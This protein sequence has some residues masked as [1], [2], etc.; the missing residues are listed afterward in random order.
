MERRP[1]VLTGIR[2]LDAA[3]GTASPPTDLRIDGGR[4][5]AIGAAV[6]RR[7]ADVVDGTG[8]YLSPGFVDMHAHPLGDA[9]PA[10]KLALMLSYGITAF[11]QM[12]GSDE[13]LAARA[14]GTLRLPEASPALLQLCGPLLIGADAATP[15]LAEAEVRRQVALGVDFVKVIAVTPEALAAAQRVARELDV[16]ILGHL[17][18]GVDVR[19]VSRAGYRSI[20]HLGPGLA[21]PAAVSREEERIREATASMR[22]SDAVSAGA[23]AAPDME[24]IVLNP[25]LETTAATLTNL[26]LAVRSFDEH[27]ARELARRFV[28]DG[29]WH[30]V[31]L[32]RD[33]TMQRADADE[34]AT[35]PDLHHRRDASRLGWRR[36]H[37]R[38]PIQRGAARDLLRAVRPAEAARQDPRR[39]GRRAP[40]GHRHRRRRLDRAGLGAARRVPRARRRRPHPGSHPATHDDRAGALPRQPRHRPRRGRSAGR[41][42]AAGLR[43][44]RRRHG[45]RSDRGRRARGAAL[46]RGGAGGHPRGAGRRGRLTIGTAE[47]EGFEPSDPQE[48]SPP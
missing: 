21:I 25:M 26:G 39:G 17:P 44:A 24:E 43:P 40:R 6:D 48:G 47:T 42:R 3:T 11:R 20:E 32:L 30:C 41:S 1:L 46:R 28:A 7:D 2:I 38:P 10:D 33:K 22:G 18:G 29:T 8:R 36:R 5:S 35:N 14:A 9:D 45:A 31:T 13:L 19:E 12:S 15:E 16:P 34:F 23:G 27:K 4:I 37:L